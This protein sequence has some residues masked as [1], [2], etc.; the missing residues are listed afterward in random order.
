MAQATL[1]QWETSYNE[2]SNTLR[3]LING[4]YLLNLTDS[5]VEKFLNSIEAMESEDAPILVP[6]QPMSPQTAEEDIFD[7]ETFEY[8]EGKFNYTLSD[9][10]LSEFFAGEHE[11]LELEFD[12]LR[13]ARNLY[14]AIL[15]HPA[16]E[17][18]F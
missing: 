1:E 9:D 10:D 12:S 18:I 3:V 16:S 6:V 2:K 11:E 5:S 17:Y 4:E 13:D 7:E 15:D 14:N 8:I